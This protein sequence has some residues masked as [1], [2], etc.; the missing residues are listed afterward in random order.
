MKTYGSSDYKGY[1]YSKKY[2]SKHY[3][4]SLNV[5]PLNFDKDCLDICI[6][7]ANN[8]QLCLRDYKVGS[9]KNIDLA[10]KTWV[11]ER[12]KKHKFVHSAVYDRLYKDKY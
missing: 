12:E 5:N 6:A 9:N 1:L 4:E 8:E 10:C 7:G 11:E 3:I 2:N